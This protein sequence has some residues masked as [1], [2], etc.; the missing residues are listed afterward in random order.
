M[1]KKHFPLQKGEKFT[2]NVLK[3]RNSK[4]LIKLQG[5]IDLL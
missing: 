3:N 5:S 4:K 2:E 1:L